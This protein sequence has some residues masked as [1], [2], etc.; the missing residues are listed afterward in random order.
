LYR[1]LLAA[2]GDPRVA[3]NLWS[4]QDGKQS[5]RIVCGVTEL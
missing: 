2:E 5:F 1:E 3:K 4:N